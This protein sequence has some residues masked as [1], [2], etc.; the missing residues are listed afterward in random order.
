MIDRTIAGAGI[1]DGKRSRADRG[2]AG[3]GIG[4]GEQERASPDFVHAPDVAAA[5]PEIV[6][7]L[8]ATVTSIVPV[9]PL[10]IVKFRSVLALAP[11]YCR[12]PP[13]NTKLAASLVD[14]PRVL[15][16][17][18]TAMLLML[19]TPPL[20]VVAPVYEFKP[21]NPTKPEVVLFSP[22][23]PPST[24]EAVPSR[25]SKLLVLVIVPAPLIR[26]DVLL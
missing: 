19:S 24:A 1:S 3:V 12:L 15:A 18:P 20:M 17:P 16:A 23:L 5:A 21:V 6:N 22:T 2:R 10:L 26:L 25:M 8:A 14:A 4:A 13:S 9:L 7:V 11:V